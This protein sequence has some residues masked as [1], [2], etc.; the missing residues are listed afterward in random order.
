M[1]ELVLE[2][3]VPLPE[4]PVPGLVPV[5]PVPLSM[6]FVPLPLPLLP[7]PP[8]WRSQADTENASASALRMINFFIGCFLF[9]DKS[10]PAIFSRS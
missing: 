3:L 4:V 2:P 8:L 5:E 7:V 6:P 1:P 9:L 10:A